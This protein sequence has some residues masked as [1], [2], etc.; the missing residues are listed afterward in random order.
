VASFLLS[1][2]PRHLQT[3]A[4]RAG[5]AHVPRMDPT[6]LATILD[7]AVPVFMSPFET[8][9]LDEP[10]PTIRDYSGNHSALLCVHPALRTEEFP[11]N[12]P[13]RDPLSVADH[14]TLLR[15]ARPNLRV[16]V[17]FMARNR[18]REANGLRMAVS[19]LDEAL[20][21]AYPIF[22]SLTPHPRLLGLILFSPRNC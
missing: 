20:A 21:P 5:P 4:F 12:Q 9:V 10:C 11:M 22:V 13:L 16:L 18:I 2:P 14:T 19:L 17:H 15:I 7:R 8:S 3:Y 6:Y 1:L